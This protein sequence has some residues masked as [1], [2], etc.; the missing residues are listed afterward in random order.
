MKHLLKS[1]LVA[2]GLFLTVGAVNAQQ[3]IGHVNSQEILFLMPEYK[4]ANQA[5]ET[6]VGTKRTEIQQMDAER[7]KK[8]TAFMDKQKTR[9]EANKET[10]DQELQTLSTEIQQ[11]EGRMGEV[12]QKAEQEVGAKREEVFQP[13]FEKAEK[14]IQAVAKE[15]GYA[16]ILDIA[17]QSVLYFE[18]GDDISAAVKTKL[19][20]DPNAKP[21]APA[22]A[23]PTTP[24]AQ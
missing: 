5:L 13:V 9:S 6:F 11:M 1:V 3:K 14:A 19:G 4:T 16:Y 23:A 21:A 18:G 15:K 24:A 7:Q 20:I 10:V 8:I 2:A 17:Q 12:Q 22:N